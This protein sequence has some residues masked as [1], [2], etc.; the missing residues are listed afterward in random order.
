MFSV[1]NSE[2]EHIVSVSSPDRSNFIDDIGSIPKKDIK[3]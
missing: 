1:L 2:D 3:K